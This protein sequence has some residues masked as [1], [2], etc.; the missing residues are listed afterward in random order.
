MLNLLEECAHALGVKWELTVKAS[1][2]RNT[3]T[4]LICL[5]VARLADQLLGCH[6][7]WRPDEFS[8]A[9][10]D[11]QYVIG[12]VLYIR[13]AFS[14]ATRSVSIHDRVWKACEAK[15]D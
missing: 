14:I 6:V 11:A 9:R 1:K 3:I 12:H 10:C 13:L 4:V 5:F 7:C 2:Q 8:M 15:V